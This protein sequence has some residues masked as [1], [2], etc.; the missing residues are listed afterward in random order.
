[1][2]NKFMFPGATMAGPQPPQKSTPS[3]D[4]RNRASDVAADSIDEELQQVS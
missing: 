4:N 2:A 1:V 3:A